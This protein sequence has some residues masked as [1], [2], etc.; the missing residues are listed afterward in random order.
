VDEQEE[1]EE[2]EEEGDEVLEPVKEKQNQAKRKGTD[3]ASAVGGVARPQR[4]KKASKKQQEVEEEMDEASK[5][6]RKRRQEVVEE[7]EDE[8]KGDEEEEEEQEEEIVLPAVKKP[9]G[10]VKNGSVVHGPAGELIFY[11]SKRGNHGVD[12]PVFGKDRDEYYEA[13]MLVRCNVVALEEAE[14]EWACQQLLRVYSDQVKRALQ[15]NKKTAV[16]ACAR[17][18]VT[19]YQQKGV[20]IFLNEHASKK[21]MHVPIQGR[22]RGR[23]RSDHCRDRAHRR[24]HLGRACCSLVQRRAPLAWS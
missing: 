6:Q 4:V 14:L 12:C 15:E 7:G 2:E 17:A 3:K 18:Y 21:G 24:R 5:P 10:K 8:E 1:E 9:K 23:A 11:S 13:K 20:R 16:E 19:L 22:E